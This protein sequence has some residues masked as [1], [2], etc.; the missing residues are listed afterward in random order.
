[1]ATW[2]VAVR[3]AADVTERLFAYINLAQL[4]A[5]IQPIGLIPDHKA[6]V[7]RTSYKGVLHFRHR[8]VRIWN[9]T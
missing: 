3:R 9:S 2:R 5:L 1:M 6:G 8:G 4:T 7:P